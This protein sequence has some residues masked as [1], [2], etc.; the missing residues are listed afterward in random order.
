MRLRSLLKKSLLTALLVFGASIAWGQI[1]STGTGGL[2]SATTTWNGGVVPVSGDVIIADGTTVTLD[3]DVSVSNITVGGGASGILEFQN[4]TTV[5]SLTLSGDLTVKSGGEFRLGTQTANVEHIFNIAGNI[6]LE[7]ASSFNIGNGSSKGVIT[8]F[9]KT[10]PGDQTVSSSGTPTLVLFGKTNVNRTNSTDKVVC[11]VSLTNKAGNKALQLINGTWEQSAGLWTGPGTTATN[12][13]MDQPNGNLILSGTGSMTLTSSIVGIGGNNGFEGSITVNTSGSLTTGNLNSNSRLQCSGTG[14]LNMVSGTINARGRLTITNVANISGGDIFIYPQ[15][16]GSALSPTSNAFEVTSGT[17]VL[18]MT[19]GNITL[20]SP[21]A[22]ATT[23]RDLKLA[24]T[25]N[26]SGGTIFI[27]DGSSTLTSSTFDGFLLSGYS[28][29]VNNLTI[30]TG[31][32]AGR[33]AILYDNISVQG[34]LNMSSG[35]IFTGDNSL[36]IGASG[37]ITGYDA[38]KFIVTSG[39]GSLKMSTLS[40]GSVTYPIGSSA[41]SYTPFVSTDNTSADVLGVNIKSGI[42]NATLDNEKCVKLEWL[43]NEG[44][45]GG[46]TGT[47]TFQWNATDQG[48]SFDPAQPVFFG[49]W[50]GTQYTNSPVTVSGTG[51][52]TVTLDAPETYP[53]YPVIFGN[54][55][56]FPVG[57]SS[58]KDIIS[59]T[60]GTLGSLKI[61]NIPATTTVADLSAGLVVS[62]GASFE[63][64]VSTGGAAATSTDIITNSMVV[65]V[66][67][68]DASSQEYSLSL[69]VPIQLIIS[70]VADPLDDFN[71]RFV[72]LYNAGDVAIDFSTTTV[73]LSRQSNGGTSYGNVQ[74]TGILDP[75][76]TYV[77][78]ALQ[79]VFEAAYGKVANIYSTVINGNGDDAYFLFKDGDNTTGTLIDIYGV[80]DQDGTGFPWEYLDGRAF[81][82]PGVLT[83]NTTWTASEW[84]VTK[85]GSN[86]ADFNPGVHVATLGPDAT[87]SDLQLDAVQIAGFNS[88]VYAYVVELP[89]GTVT[90]PNITYTL[91]DNLANASFTAASDLTG[92]EAARTATIA[93]TSADGSTT[94]N[95]TVL[96]N[97]ILE[98]ATLSVLRTADVTRTYVLTG[99]VLLTYMNASRNQKFIQDATGGAMID[100][101]TGVITTT[102][103]IGDKI[104]G[105][106][107]KVLI[108]NGL[109]EFV[110]VEN[111][112]PAVTSGNP[113]VAEEITVEQFNGEL[114]TYEGKF[115]KIKGAVFADAGATFAKANYNFTVGATTGVL[116]ANYADLDYIGVAIPAKADISGVV[117]QYKGTAQIVPRSLADFRV[118]SSNPNIIEMFVNGTAVAGFDFL[119]LN[120]AVTLPVGTTELPAITYTTANA[121]ATVEVTNATNL[122]GT[123]A[124]RTATLVVTAEDGVATKTYTIVFTVDNTGVKNIT[125]AGITM[126]PVPATD[127]LTISGLAKTSRLDLMDLTGKVIRSVGNTADEITIDISDLH[128]GMYFI[129]TDSQTLKFIKK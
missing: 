10:T 59:T 108:Y 28:A 117:I 5:R 101:A 56:A 76:T 79:T 25:I 52:Y 103:A 27:G 115:V 107:G 50:E 61:S 35:L 82:V 86:M 127:Q 22:A 33:N 126:Y 34:T 128:K 116:R 110:P 69:L 81:R 73:Y 16:V 42:T 123:E 88:A 39:T 21:N 112:G 77:V 17:G 124:E 102:Y 14:V 74:L 18:N 31:G 54:Q 26:I 8:N 12:L 71:G 9:N 66:T 38:S 83:P 30:Q 85:G 109:L 84:V 125:G 70:E 57:L 37:S 1:S 46:N 111:P 87:L 95:Y 129:R 58:A 97:P 19:G 92:D 100:D 24:G 7:N 105:I 4:T 104:T 49:A 106:K 113:V 72:E 96:F 20:V 67:A 78:A 90:A 80:K 13:W 119:V 36:T 2:W 63:I 15:G 48:S 91:N 93:V 62:G 11:S 118:V 55:G 64:L 98:A 121:N 29:S 68:E 120:Y 44:S 75:G 65:K 43:G 99:E 51:P 3:Q 41:T 40:V 23:G 32:I 53:A 114:N 47:V 6:I 94:Q 89:V 45:A 60:I 122:F